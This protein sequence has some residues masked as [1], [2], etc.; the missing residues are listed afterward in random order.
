MHSLIKM[1]Y[2]NCFHF[3]AN[4]ARYAHRSEQSLR[5]Q[6]D[7][8]S[9]VVVLKELSYFCSQNDVDA[10]LPVPKKKKTV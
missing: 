5:A 10:P 1:H 4:I 2:F 7:A 8:L 9:M 6:I 3:L